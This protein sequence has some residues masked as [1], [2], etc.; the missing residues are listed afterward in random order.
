M[1]LVWSL[2][3]IYPTEWV[4][5]FT[6][7]ELVVQPNLGVKA[8]PAVTGER[9]APAGSKSGHT[10]VLFEEDIWRNDPSEGAESLP[11]GHMAVHTLSVDGSVISGE[12]NLFPAFSCVNQTQ[13]KETDK[14]GFI[15]HPP[16]HSPPYISR[17]RVFAAQFL[18]TSV[19][20]SQ[21]NFS[22]FPH[23]HLSISLSDRNDCRE[24]RCVCLI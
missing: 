11:R 9:W 13:H 3:H 7:S 6:Q 21:S 14:S 8:P 23:F 17:S 20:Q 5:S 18:S 16:I 24:H 19:A 15:H 4:I 12:S 1:S 2:I 10:K 22:A